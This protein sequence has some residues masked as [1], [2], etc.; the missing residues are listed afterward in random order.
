MRNRYEALLVLDTEGKEES[1]QDMVDRLSG[2]FAEE[3]ASVEQV[4]RM[5]KRHFSYVAGKLSAGYYVNFVFSG[6]PDVIEKLKAR[7]RFDEDVY[8][9][10]YQK[11]GSAD[12]AATTTTGS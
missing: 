2:V 5:E 4:Q 11:L 7:L 8:R 9:Q 10:H 6:E 3:G 12:T 1:V